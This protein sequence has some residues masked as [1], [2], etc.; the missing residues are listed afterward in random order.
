MAPENGDSNDDL[1]TPEVPKEAGS[2]TRRAAITLDER[3]GVFTLTGQFAPID[4]NET[5]EGRS[6]RAETLG[7]GGAGRPG[8]SGGPDDSPR[9][10]ARS[11]T[12]EVIRAILEFSSL[13]HEEA[14][15]IPKLSEEE[16]RQIPGCQYLSRAVLEAMAKRTADIGID[17]TLDVKITFDS[18]NI[19]TSIDIVGSTNAQS[20]FTDDRCPAEL[21]TRFIHLQSKILSI[22]TTI[23]ENFHGSA[24]G[25]QGD[26]VTA[27]FPNEM[28]AYMA[29]LSIKRCL[30]APLKELRGLI[31]EFND[32]H[33]GGK[34]TYEEKAG[35][36]CVNVPIDAGLTIQTHPDITGSIIRGGTLAVSESFTKEVKGKEADMDTN[37]TN[38]FTPRESILRLA[39][40][41]L[42]DADQTY[43]SSR[44]RIDKRTPL[45]K[46]A[47]VIAEGSQLPTNE[48]ASKH[49]NSTLAVPFCVYLPDMDDTVDESEYHNLISRIVRTLR[50]YQCEDVKSVIEG[51]G[52]FTTFENGDT[53]QL[54]AKALRA[55]RDVIEEFNSPDKKRRAICGIGKKGR[56]VRFRAGDDKRH[57]LTR[58][59]RV[60]NELFR[61][62]ATAIRL[63]EESSPHDEERESLAISM[64]QR[65]KIEKY[66]VPGETHDDDTAKGIKGG[67]TITELGVVKP[68]QIATIE[69]SSGNVPLIGAGPASA[70]AKVNSLFDE[71]KR[72][73]KMRGV[74]PVNKVIAQKTLDRNDA[75]SICIVEPEGQNALKSYQVLTQIVGKFISSN[76]GAAVDEQVEDDLLVAIGSQDEIGTKKNLTK[77]FKQA[78][79]KEE[80]AL[81]ICVLEA[82]SMDPASRLILEEVVK[83]ID[84][85]KLRLI[86]VGSNLEEPD[87]DEDETATVSRE[88]AK[89]LISYILKEKAGLVTT[90]LISPSDLD[91]IASSLPTI[92]VEK[93]KRI[94]GAFV[95][96]FI[97]ELIDGGHLYPGTKV[98]WVVDESIH[99]AQFQ[100]ESILTRKLNHL[101]KQ[102]S[103]IT[104]VAYA[105]GAAKRPITPKV[106]ASALGED[107]DG[108]KTQKLA[109]KLASQGLIIKIDFEEED[110]PE[111]APREGREGYVI[112]PLYRQAVEK[113]MEGWEERRTAVHR[114]IIEDLNATVANLAPATYKTPPKDEDEQKERTKRYRITKEHRGMCLMHYAE[115]FKHF[116]EDTL[117]RQSIEW[118]VEYLDILRMDAQEDLDFN[119]R[120]SATS[121]LKA[122]FKLEKRILKLQPTDPNDSSLLLEVKRKYLELASMFSGAA[123]RSRTETDKLIDILENPEYLIA[124]GNELI[125]GEV[126]E[127]EQIEAAV[128]LTLVRACM[129]MMEEMHKVFVNAGKDQVEKTVREQSI[130]QKTNAL[131]VR[132]RG[133][134]DRYRRKYTRLH[135]N[136]RKSNDFKIGRC[137]AD[138]C[139]DVGL[140][141]KRHIR[142]NK[143]Y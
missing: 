31:K 23:I 64:A 141:D 91:L 45:S 28:L 138:L 9:R 82:E 114:R 87:I 62:M 34:N 112:A 98:A 137:T 69:T 133:I 143:R 108:T 35:I 101:E 126:S 43:I 81:H 38:V 113:N 58:T 27:T 92:E 121:K 131:Y 74:S 86:I 21:R 100:E 129:T 54:A 5:F 142:K 79:S 72:I 80:K 24:D 124:L 105:I 56:V 140:C 48:A 10:A 67:I 14:I 122:I 68:K 76:F 103:G 30:E 139:M 118:L 90:E 8:G 55:V 6:E 46:L 107:F 41:T 83:G 128:G 7:P 70:L 75:G 77:Y 95:F 94:Q 32:K 52:L 120:S 26:E 20:A 110:F 73:V 3:T 78:L 84:N 39:E 111:G 11:G 17:P 104:E 51:R 65:D 117:D 53:E 13:S 37:T 89:E 40:R 97:G 36:R 116:Q 66:C 115:Y 60:V 47:T 61:G 99:T 106:L 63:Y 15:A 88:E 42:P 12:T 59:G 33:S 44:L 134:L 71:E 1:D 29:C 85:P 57:E 127:R 132:A 50:D 119:N 109:T 96:P 25:F 22:S 102:E 16:L 2:T 123:N 49:A 18:N 136:G 19:Y 4:S 125:V 135:S 93:E 130:S